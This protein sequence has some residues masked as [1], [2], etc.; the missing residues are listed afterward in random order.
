MSARKRFV[1]PLCGSFPN[2]ENRESRQSRAARPA[3]V[4]ACYTALR[5]RLFGRSEPDLVGRI[6]AET[7]R[8]LSAALAA[9]LVIGGCSPQGS[10]GPITASH[11]HGTDATLTCT[12]PA[13]PLG[14]LPPAVPAWCVTLTAG[15]DSA[16]RGVNSWT[17]EFGSAA[18]NARL[19]TSYRVFE[20][21]RPHTSTV[22]RTQ[23]FA[24]NGHWMVDVAGHG[25]ALGVYSGA[26]DDFEIGPN[27]GGALM[28]PGVAFRVAGGGL[29]IQGGVAAGVEGDGD[30]SWAAV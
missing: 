3:D 16:I 22:F 12:D 17:D 21:G 26:V 14:A 11:T 27:N 6:L 4:P 18:V 7:M 1:M 5:S 15:V 2:T 8:V 23:H 10:S 25:A 24:Q 19:S 20:L 13:T 28:R 30:H 29:V 9:L